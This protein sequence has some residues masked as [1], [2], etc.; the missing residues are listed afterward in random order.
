MT[1]NYVFAGIAVSDYGAALAWYER[2][3]G[4]PPDVIVAENE[5]MWQVA[6]AGW[7]YVVGDPA[8]AGHG[9]FAF[10]VDD[11]DRQVAELAQRGLAVGEIETLPGSARKV[12]LHDPEGNKITVGEAPSTDG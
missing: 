3:L 10:L 12:V 2:L 8:R 7:V 9:L 6:G 5:A 1:I 11:L 4:R